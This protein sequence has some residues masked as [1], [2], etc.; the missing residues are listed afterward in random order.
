MGNKAHIIYG[1]RE[2]SKPNRWKIGVA[3]YSSGRR[4]PAKKRQRAHANAKSGCPKFDDHLRSCFRQGSCFEEVFEYFELETF[5]GDREG[6]EEREVHY[7]NL[8]N[9]IWPSGFCMV[10]GPTPNV[11]QWKER[12]KSADALEKHAESMASPEVKEKLSKSGKEAWNKPE[13]RKKFEDAARTPESRKKRSQICENAW[14]NPETRAKRI[15][16]LKKAW[17]FRK[18]K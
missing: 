3:E 12:V 13:I 9:A 6:A 15:E 14:K 5:F 11:E 16:G 10:A 17:V 1:Y 2:I 7:T 8:Y 4:N 18:K